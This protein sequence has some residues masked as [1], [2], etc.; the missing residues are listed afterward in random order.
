[1]KTNRIWILLA[2]TINLGCNQPKN[3][4]EKTSTSTN[5]KDSISIIIKP[6][7][8]SRNVTE[9]EIPVLKGTNIRHGIQ[10]RYY[11]HGSIYSEIPY[12]HGK[13]EGM[14]KTYYPA[15][16]SESPA[17]WKEQPYKNNELNGICYRYHRNGKLQ[18]EYEYKDG[19]PAVGLKEFNTSG[20]PIN[21]PTLILSKSNTNVYYYVTAQMSDHE[22]NVD[23]YVGDLVEGKYMPE[24]LKGLQVKN[25][26][27]EILLPLNTKKVT[28]TAEMSTEYKNKYLVSKTISF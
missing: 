27:G 23:Y 7:E 1:M 21:L 12:V 25:G 22:K 13:R 19:L 26:V 11:L 6:Y 18:A 24:N 3:Q 4:Q 16:T 17:V 5:E 8:N 9:Y 10:K 14:A 15:T 20:K 28:I 2:L